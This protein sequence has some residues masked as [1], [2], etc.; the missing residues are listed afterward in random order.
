[1][2]KSLYVGAMPSRTAHT[3]WMVAEHV[4]LTSQRVLSFSE[5]FDCKLM[6]ILWQT[7]KEGRPPVPEPR[8]GLK[9][10]E[11]PRL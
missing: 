2:S 7:G 6:V 11:L 1:M 9:P 10:D 8:E 3:R 4:G 5:L